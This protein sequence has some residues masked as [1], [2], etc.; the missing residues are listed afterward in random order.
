MAPGWKMPLWLI[1]LLYIGTTLVAGI[2]LPRLEAAYLADYSHTVAVAS[3]Q[4]FFSAVS[5][6]IMALTGIVFAIT[7]V[8]IQFSAVAYSP[9]VVAMFAGR[10]IMFHAMGVFIAT[11]TYSLAALVWTDRGGTGT[12]PLFSSMLVFVLLCIS[13]L[14]FAYLIQS[15]GDLQINNVLEEIGTKGRSVIRTMFPRLPV[16]AQCEPDIDL[17]PTFEPGSTTQTLTYSGRPQS[18]ARLDIAGLVRIAQQAGAVIEMTCAVGDTLVEDCTV[19]RLHKATRPIPE[20]QLLRCIHLSK[21]RT[22][23]QDPKYAIRLLVDIAIRALSPAVNDP[24]TA[25]QALDQVEDLLR[26]LGRSELDAGRAHD[27][28]GTLR[29]VFPMPTWD[30]YLALSFDE[31]RQFGTISIQVV[32]RMRAALTGLAS[33]VTLPSRQQSILNYRS[34]L[35]HKVEYSDFDTQDRASAMREDQQGLGLSRG[36]PP[37]DHQEDT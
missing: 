21:E 13:L 19:L 35:D 7:I 20:A 16:D 11:F 34:H 27:A 24:T 2:V 4:A 28:A 25:V 5:S 29:L 15:V 26:R 1:P 31:I 10:R 32:R 22:F 3:A 23:E 12:V 37:D 17:R 18:I 9:R 6:G 14:L 30:D 33:T 8:M 36:L